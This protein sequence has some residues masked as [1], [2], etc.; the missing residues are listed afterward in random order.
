VQFIPDWRG[1]IWLGK[2]S[3]LIKHAYGAVVKDGDVF[4]YELGDT[5]RCVHKPSLTNRGQ[6][7]A[8]YCV[9]VLPDGSKH[10]EVMPKD[11]LDAIRKR[12]KASDDGPW[13]TDTDAMYIKT[14]VKRALKPFA[15]SP[16]L[17]TA[18]EYDNSVLGL[19][20]AN[21]RPPVQMPVALPPATAP[22]AQSEAPPPSNGQTVSG[23]IEN[24]STKPGTRKDGSSFTKYGILVN[25]TYYGTFEPTLGEQAI[26]MK[27][28]PATLQVEQNGKYWNCTGIL[29]DAA[30]VADELFPPANG[31]E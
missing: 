4:D 6:T 20:D 5:P 19:A 28:Q 14:V 7:V 8:A 31:K 30:D 18:L 2:K 26:A 1:L 23:V 24:V 9:V 21:D 16:Q 10:V 15:G 22:A 27:G 3:D 11:D 29:S 25:G 17:H 13:V 12:S